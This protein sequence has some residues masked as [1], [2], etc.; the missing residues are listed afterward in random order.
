MYEITMIAL[1]GVIFYV[2][3]FHEEHNLFKVEG[4]S[5]KESEKFRKKEFNNNNKNS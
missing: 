4:H 2:L 3:I 5:F 1:F